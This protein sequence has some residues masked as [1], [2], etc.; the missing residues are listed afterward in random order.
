MPNKNTSESDGDNWQFNKTVLQR[1]KHMLENCLN[2][3]VSFVV[4]GISAGM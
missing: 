1:N 3:D 4:G 2:M